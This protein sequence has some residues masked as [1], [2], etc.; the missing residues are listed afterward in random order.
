MYYS[1]IKKVRNTIYLLFFIGFGLMVAG[2]TAKVE[3]DPAKAEKKAEF[4]KKMVEDYG[5]ERTD[6]R[7][8]RPMP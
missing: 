4:K 5:G 7:P 3:N 6:R 1:A 8:P 2:C